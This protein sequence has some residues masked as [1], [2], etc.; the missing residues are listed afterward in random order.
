MSKTIYKGALLTGTVL[1]GLS[2]ANPAFAQS[3]P[4][5]NTQGNSPPAQADDENLP[6]GVQS[7]ESAEGAEP[8]STN[9][10]VVTGTLIRNPNLVSSA[11][12]TVVGQEEIQLRQTNVAEEVL[13]TIPGA[14]PSIGSNVNNGSGGAAFVNLRGLGSNRNLVL[15]DGVRIAPAGLGGQV[16][17]NN[18]PL[19]LVDRVDVLTGG[20]S[21]TYGA[22][23]ISGV[24]NFITRSDFAGMELNASNQITERGDGNVIRTDLTIGAN[25]DG[26]RGNAVL[27]LGY[28]ESD[29]VFFGAD[30]P[31]SQV[32]LESYDE[33]FVAGQGSTTTSPSA[34]DIGGGRAR[35]Q[36]SA[37]GTGIQNF[38]SAYNFNP[39]NVFQTPFKRYNMY[40]A[41]HFDITDNITVYSRGLYSNNTVSTIIAPSG[42]FA[43][44]VTVPVSNPF[45]SA[46]QRTY[47][48]ANADFN[49]GTAGNQT[50]TAAE[51]A[52]AATATA[53]TD[54]NFREFTVGLRRR[55]P[56]VGP[57]VSEYNTA[58][59]DFRAGIRGDITDRMGFDVFG[60]RG[61][62]VNTSSIQNYVLLSRARQAV[63]ATNTTTCIN[64]ANGCVPINIFGSAGTLGTD[65][66]LDF[67]SDDATTVISTTLSQ[68]R[69][70]LNGD[71]GITS[72]FAA[73]P[74]GFAVGAEYRDYGAEQRSDALAKTAGELGGAG[75][76][77]PDILGGYN[78]YEGFAEVIAPLISD[79]PFFNELTI[80][81][82]IRRS[83]Y[84]VDA[85]TNP[86]FKTTTWKVAG[87][88]EPV[89][90][91]KFRGNYQ[92]SVR[93]PNIGELF[94]PISTGLTNLGTDPCA[95]QAP[96]GNAN[97][98][99]ICIAQGAPAATIGF[100]SNPTAGQANA[101]GGGNPLLRPE[102]AKTWTVGA[103]LRPSFLRNFSATI[104][105]YNVKITGAVSSPTPQDVIAAC[106]GAT[107]TAPG[108]NA[109]LPACTSIGRNPVSGGLDGPP[110]T[111]T[112]LP[113]ALSN[114]GRIETDGVDLTANYRLTLGQILGTPARLNFSFGGNWT[115][116]STFQATPTAI[117]RECTGF[118]SVNCGSIQPKY[119]FTQRTTLGL[120]AVDIS[121]LWRYLHK[122][123]LEPLQQQGDLDSAL[124]DPAGCPSPLGTDPGGCIIDERFRSI[125]AYN[126][127]DLT[128]RFNV[129]DNFQFTAT[130]LN[131][132]DKD[133]PIVGGTV[134]STTYNG[135]NTY[136]SSYDALGRRFAIGAR[137]KF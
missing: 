67:L 64:P 69:G 124:A 136:P 58:V 40:A 99:A 80:E 32:T 6:G 34:F 129:T 14:V 87:S 106:F 132:F 33:F 11:P 44:T 3:A 7:S 111:T 37:D 88:W 10:I 35:Q 5:T 23:A 77:A 27:A 117:D 57:R 110:D 89:S 31:Y 25:F 84:A 19:S 76:A 61:E 135:G 108:A 82:G 28:I 78:V 133:P 8:T 1:A 16:D 102:K 2:F 81:A 70:T 74:I 127:F 115:R 52:A 68:V 118:Y 20:A 29:P 49:T 104:D 41:G 24:V 51:C 73:E 59:W 125:D 85:P 93:A 15:L 50:L 66:A 13:R 79:R 53:A 96:V 46:A 83:S 56:E 120:G 47:F 36:I 100:I 137:V 90:D 75:G 38:Y 103:V 65:A 72:P 62:S 134:G 45:L 128:T 98:R 95:G 42:V 122:A 43:S 105:Y 63:R 121:L 114:L 4:P 55:T 17:L 116:N 97:L 123:K 60:S 21:S 86:K 54:P 12:V 113:S 119:S 9:E 126:Y 130:V 112:G 18:I 48:C 91:I 39:F 131:L 26:G 94:S 71:V 101:T 30:R 92:R 109:G 22:D 107:P